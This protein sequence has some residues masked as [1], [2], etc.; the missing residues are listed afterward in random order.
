MKFWLE[1]LHTDL[2]FKR[3]LSITE[4]CGAANE[5]VLSLTIYLR[6]L[7]MKK[8]LIENVFPKMGPMWH[9]FKY[10]WATIWITNKERETKKKGTITCFEWS[11]LFES[12]GN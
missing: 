2:C 3:E 11:E 12:E 7:S 6:A 5:I 10:N 9:K 8:F 1:K 4:G